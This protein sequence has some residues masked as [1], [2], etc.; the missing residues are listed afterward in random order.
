M[1][2]G[3]RLSAAGAAA[4]LLGLAACGGNGGSTQSAVPAISAASN[5]TT[6]NFTI[7]VPG[8]V[9][10]AATVRRPA[11]ISPNSQSAAIT[12][13][14]VNG[15]PSTQAAT[16]VDLTPNSKSCS[17]SSGTLVCSAA[18]PAPPGSDAFSLT[19]YSA[20]GGAGSKL[21]TGTVTATIKPATLN[22]VPLTL[23]GI[24][25]AIAVS[26]SAP[27]ALG[28]GRPA[29]LGVT[30]TATDASGAT[31]IGPG[32][33]QP[34]ITLTDNDTSGHTSLSSTVVSAPGGKPIVL[35]YDGSPSLIG[36]T[37]TIAATASA[38]PPANIRAA[39]FTA[40][41]VTRGTISGAAA[42]AVLSDPLGNVVATIPTSTGVATVPI[43]AA[44]GVV[45]AHARTPSA[46]QRKP[47]AVAT[48][49]PVFPITPAPDECAPDYAHDQLECMSYSS[50]IISIVAYNPA[51]VLSALSLVGQIVTDA[52]SP[53]VTF[54]GATCQVCGIAY[55]P[56]DNAAIIS[57][58]NGYELYSP[59]AATL[60]PTG[61]TAPLTTVAAP[62]SENF[63]YNANTD[64]IFSP[65]YALD[66]TW[67]APN[68]NLDVINLASATGTWFDLLPADVPGG[69]SE[70]D[71]GAVD[72]TTGIAVAPEEDSYP[73]YLQLLPAPGSSA[74]VP[75]AHAANAPGG[76]VNMAVAPITPSAVSLIPNA[77]CEET[78][79]AVD[80]NKDLAFFGAEFSNTDCIAIAQLPTS[81][82]APTGFSSYVDAL[83]PNLP[84][85][86]AFASPDDPH[87]ALTANI[88]DLC[89]DCGVLFN[90][91]KSYV[92][93]VDL[94]KFLALAPSASPNGYD[95]PTSTDL[96]TPGVVTY[97]ATNVSS[98]PSAF[99]RAR[100][101][102]RK[103]H[104]FRNGL[105]KHAL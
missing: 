76:T 38:I 60:S 73:I 103:A 88:T 75:A 89:T 34:S 54:S 18:V 71:A 7:K 44:G 33:Y 21:S 101:T 68:A 42:F 48:A 5:G 28:D 17:S 64:Q 84:N 102:Y 94:N 98:P 6:A 51:N 10:R 35:N 24:V 90:Y 49:P 27:N 43:V 85:G 77:G 96:I 83:L 59:S 93:I 12:L 45:L 39:T 26:L 55:D 16:I 37:V 72:T 2:I 57:T 20:P 82:V 22:T 65:Y 41:P 29:S 30:V 95:V 8:G 14:S 52:P 19:L 104:P 4:A 81:A 70:P 9:S 69:I 91:D 32:A 63:G 87:A 105:R 58:A 3:A 1:K 36:V 80:S 15:T 66:N 79:T 11:Y 25:S 100:A 74:F 31:I 46:Q 86:A 92:A 40:V 50:N 47:A 99:A 78:Y 97:I 56:T 23:N 53:G 61:V 62:I 67:S 13:V